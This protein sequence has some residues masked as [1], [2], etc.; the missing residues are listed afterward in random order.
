MNVSNAAEATCPAHPAK[1][2]SD[3]LDPIRSSN[4]T[5]EL[6]EDL[7]PIH[8]RMLHA[9][10]AVYRVGE[11]FEHLHLLHSGFVKIV[12]FSAD[13]REQVVALHL[14][15]DW[16]GFDG[17]AH[18]HY[19]CDAIAMHTGEV[20]S[21]RYDTLLQACSS[22][23]ALLAVL[24][25]AM[26]Q[27]M[28]RDRESLMALCTLTADARVAEFLRYWADSLDRRGLRTDR[29]SLRMTR[30]EMG[31]YLGMT[32]ESVS[33]AL[34]RLAR[35]HVIHFAEKGHREVQIPSI[36]ALNAFVHETLVPRREALQ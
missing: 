31:S 5:F 34:T 8:R 33:R 9:G 36:E 17:I 32:L 19:G 12:N 30:A 21:I 11:H 13:G 20:W 4:D 10:D 18:G 3:R 1:L 2:R 23:P 29:I 25:E 22:Q 28:E 27:A 16:L 15:G 24:H 26:S 35:N 7:L 14:K 6:L